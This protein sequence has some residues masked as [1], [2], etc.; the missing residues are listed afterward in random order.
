MIEPGSHEMYTRFASALDL[1]SVVG[2]SSLTEDDIDQWMATEPVGLERESSLK[3]IEF[4]EEPTVADSEGESDEDLL[5]QTMAMNRFKKCNEPVVVPAAPAEAKRDAT[6]DDELAVSLGAAAAAARGP[7]MTSELLNEDEDDE[8]IPAPS[9]VLSLRPPLGPGLTSPSQ[10][11]SAIARSAKPAVAKPTVT[12]ADEDDDDEATEDEDDMVVDAVVPAPVPPAVEEDD[13]D[14]DEDDDQGMA[15]NASK[16]STETLEGVKAGDSSDAEEDVFAASPKVAKKKA[17]KATKAKSAKAPTKKR[18]RASTSALDTPVSALASAST[19]SS[20]RI[21]RAAAA[22]GAASLSDM[23]GK[24]LQEDLLRA[25][26]RKGA[27]V[28]MNDDGTIRKRGSSSIA[29]PTSSRVKRIKLDDGAA[30]SSSSPAK[31]KS[32]SSSVDGEDEGEVRVAWSGIDT[33][34]DGRTDEDVI[35]ELGEIGIVLDKTDIANATHFVLPNLMRT[36][37]V[38]Q[39]IPNAPHFVKTEWVKA[40]LDKVRPAL[41]VALLMPFAG[42]DR[43]GQVVRV[44]GRR[45][46]SGREKEQGQADRGHRPCA[47][48]QDGRD[49][50]SRRPFVLRHAESQAHGRRYQ[51]AQA[52][53]PRQRRRAP[54]CHAGRRR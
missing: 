18:A 14:E 51:V 46:E 27:A 23:A 22:K 4:G 24:Q 52:R 17:V 2:A 43:A 28:K 6:S 29:R 13:D 36:L 33:L 21:Q 10:H 11:A 41:A 53:H 50:A 34:V 42:Q 25:R 19:S 39:A 15:V 8:A 9:D 30:G 7:D 3:M 48:L 16:L 1:N 37:A 45:V 49:H 26:E 32:R 54:R 35:R 40:C 44:D 20:G 31:R 47:R 5:V 12:Q 38:L